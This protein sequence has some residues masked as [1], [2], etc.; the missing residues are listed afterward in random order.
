MLK[1]IKQHS[2][3]SAVR[4]IRSKKEELEVRKNTRRN[5]NK[6]GTK[7]SLLSKVCLANYVLHT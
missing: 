4:S 3:F 7:S 5:T 2:F 1:I 6:E